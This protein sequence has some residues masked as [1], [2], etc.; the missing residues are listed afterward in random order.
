ML[1]P[2]LKALLVAPNKELAPLDDRPAKSMREL[3]LA[4]P[5]GVDGKLLREY[6]AQTANLDSYSEAEEAE[7]AER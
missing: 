1:T 6:A 4:P 7:E 3:S 5:P 2:E